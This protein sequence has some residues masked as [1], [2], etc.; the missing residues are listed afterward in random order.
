M[1]NDEQ[2]TPS[3]TDWSFAQEMQQAFVDWVKK[4]PF[5]NRDIPKDPGREV[6]GEGSPDQMSAPHPPD[7]ALAGGPPDDKTRP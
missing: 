7:G 3:K 4:L 6:P 5:I 2:T 1:K